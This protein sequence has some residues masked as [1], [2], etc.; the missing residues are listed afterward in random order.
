M[1][2]PNRYV[3]IIERIFLSLYKSGAEEVPFER[4]DIV[5]VARK[6]DI[7]LNPA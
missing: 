7:N 4:E 6:L 5:R 1:P 2:Q 3:K